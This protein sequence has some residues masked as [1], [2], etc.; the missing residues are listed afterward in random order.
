M[1]GGRLTSNSN[2]TSL[3]TCIVDEVIATLSG[4]DHIFSKTL[5]SSVVQ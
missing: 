1:V 2:L 5:S 4:N 3:G